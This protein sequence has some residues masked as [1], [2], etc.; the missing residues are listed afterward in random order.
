MVK[1]HLIGQQAG[2]AGSVVNGCDVGDGSDT[3]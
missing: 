2:D 1:L 3:D